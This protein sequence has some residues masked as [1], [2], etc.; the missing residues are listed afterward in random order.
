MSQAKNIV[1][2]QEAR[3]I[4]LQGVNLLAD[5]VAVTMGPKGRCVVIQ[6]AYGSPKV[7]KDGVTVAKEVHD[8][9]NFI[10][11]AID[12]VR[13][14]AI[15]TNDG[16][17]DG[18]TTA[19]V[20]ARA[21]Y[22][23]GVKRVSAGLDPMGLLRGIKIA[24]K[25]AEDTLEQISIPCRDD[26]SIAQ[27]GTVSANGDET[28]GS[29][30]AKAMSVVGKEG[31]IT[32]EEGSLTD[33]LKTVEGMQFDRGYLSPYFVNNQQ[34]MSAEL[35]NPH[36]LL[37]DEKISSIRDMVPLLESIAK[38]GQPLLIIAEDVEGE[39]M[40][41]LVVNSMRGI[42]K[43][44]AVKAPGFGDRRKAMLQDIAILT[45]ATVISKEVGLSLAS[46]T[47]ED[48]GSAQRVVVTKDTTTIIDGQGTEDQIKSR[49]DQIRREMENVTSDYDREKL[50][51]RLAK[52]SGGV[53]VIMV[54]GYTELEV[55]EKKGRVEDALNAVRA[56]VD[57]GVVPGG[58]VA[59]VRVAEALKDLKGD[60]EDQNTGIK[61]VLEALKDPLRQIM[62]NAGE[63]SSVILN[64]VKDG[65]GN[66]GYNVA[67]GEFG[68]MIAMGIMDPTK[69]S[70]TA[71]VNA[72]SIAGL[73]ITTECLIVNADNEKESDG[74]GM[75]GMGGMM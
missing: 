13:Q 8:K 73:M 56:A 63:D 3:L 68:D 23:E 47:I 21:I 54:G 52:L 64:Q 35:E 17:G 51:E 37:V 72:A 10:Q 2:G 70:L 9:D 61:I 67:T 28:I 49:I 60:N 40:A 42:V 29:M 16:A 65:A 5:A 31:V 4:M 43:V 44:A 32:V 14:A 27:V 19:T 45:N 12:M 18:T 38:S 55:K 50:Q 25:A 34:N 36:I 15:K 75:G 69:V 53:A 20:L 59:L 7:T 66:F 58:G 30:I 41:T 26:K 46:T 48:L 1:Y 33:S 6:S 24:V 11:T 62:N 74:G 71:L 22:S 57:K 39:A